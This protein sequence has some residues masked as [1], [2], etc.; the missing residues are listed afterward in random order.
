MSQ[1]KPKIACLSNGP[2]LLKNDEST[3]VTLN[4]QSH[5]AEGDTP[6]SGV[7]LCRC[8]GSK[9]KPYCDGSHNQ[10]EFE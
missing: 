8:G 1:A 5:E 2:Y 9:N 4:V 10:V 7:A 6:V 3:P